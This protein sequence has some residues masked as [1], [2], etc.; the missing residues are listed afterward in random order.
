MSRTLLT[1]STVF[2]VLLVMYIWG[3]SSIRGFNFCM[4]IGVITGS[5][6]SIAIAAPLLLLRA[7]GRG[8]K[9]A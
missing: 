8:G 7:D 2:I 3:G 5:Y 1:A 4:L 6:S 9:A